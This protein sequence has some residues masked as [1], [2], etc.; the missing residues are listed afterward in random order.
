M[1]MA[2]LAR[3]TLSKQQD[4]LEQSTL[5]LTEAIFVPLPWDTS[6]LNIAATFNFI[7]CTI[8]LRAEESRQLRDVKCCILYLRHLHGEFRELPIHF[9]RPVIAALVNALVVRGELEP[10][11][12]DQGS[13]EMADLCHELLDSDIS[14]ESLPSP[15]LSFARVV[16]ARL[17]ASFE[18]KYPS[19]K[20]IRCLRRATMR[21]PDFHEIS[22]VLA[23]S[24]FD[25]YDITL[26][27]DDY[28]EDGCRRKSH[29]FP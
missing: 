22:I 14:I 11:D 6:P 3:Y 23:Q 29:R 12:V 18:G 5:C 15:I 28:E 20:V 7:A 19:E 21:L 26:L 16:D 25:R 13:E 1:A 2:R 24:P 17:Q 4:D 9:P 10:R 8:L 27:D